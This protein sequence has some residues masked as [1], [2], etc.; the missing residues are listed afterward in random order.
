MFQTFRVVLVAVTLALMMSG[1]GH[2]YGKREGCGD[3]SC[4]PAS[5]SGCAEKKAEMKENCT[6]CK[7]EEAAPKQ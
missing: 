7:S 3:K 1:C 4:N 5:C 6:K 2:Y